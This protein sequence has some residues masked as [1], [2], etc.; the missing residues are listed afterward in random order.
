MSAITDPDVGADTGAAQ[1]T[2]LD[3]RSLLVP[4]PAGDDRPGAGASFSYT[5]T[6]DLVHA[7]YSGGRVRLGH[8]VG[9]MRGNHL[10]FR[11]AEVLESGEARGGKADA[12]LEVLPDGRIRLYEIWSADGPGHRAEGIGV[13][14]EAPAA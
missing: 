7:T 13:A 9:I 5:Q 14:E 8:R 1:P 12:R 4:G 3:G 10:E 2:S 6:G 11:W